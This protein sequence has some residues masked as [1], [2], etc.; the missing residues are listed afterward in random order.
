LRWL[1]EHGRLD[2][3]FNIG[4]GSGVFTV[5]AAQAGAVVHAFEPDQEAFGIAGSSLPPR[6]TLEPLSLGEIPGHDVAR[7][8]VLHDV[9]EHIPNE[10][11]AVGA[12]HR[13]LRPDGLLVLSVPAMPSL[14]GFHDEELG[15][16]RRYTKRSLRTALNPWF[17]IDN[18]R[19]FGL[20][21]IPIT[22]WFSKLRRRPYSG[23]GDGRLIRVFD[24]VCRLEELVSTPLGTS[25]ICVA[26]PRAIAVDLRDP[27]VRA[28][29]P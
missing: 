9:L 13:L 25:L 15:H 12:L 28:P 23:R 19:Y 5:M 29:A 20:T 22:I 4:C 10:A 6:C 18:I 24:A 7:V 27:L 21:F 8:I 14:F 16:E 11:A 2:E 17:E 26:R 1:G 3:I